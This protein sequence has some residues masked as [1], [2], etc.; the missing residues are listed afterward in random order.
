MNK[1]EVSVIV[2][3][4][5]VSNFLPKC[6]QSIIEQSFKDIEI[7]CINDG[8]TD[9]S[10]DILNSFA[11]L[12]E[13]IILINQPNQGVSKARNNGLAAAK[14]KF[15]LFIDGDDYI[16]SDFIEKLHAKAVKTG[17]DIVAS[18]TVYDEG[19]QLIKNNF[20]SKQTFKINKEI[21]S[22]IEDK[23]SFAK[24]VIA[25]GKLYSSEFVRKYNLKFLEGCRFEDNEFS[26][27]ASVFAEKIALEKDAELYYVMHSGSLTANA[28]YTDTIFDF[29]KVFKEISAKVKELT[30]ENLINPEYLDVFNAHMTNAFYNT[31]KSASET[32]KSEFQKQAV[33]ILKNID[34]N[35]KYF[36][37]KT[38]KR[39]NKLMGISEPFWKKFAI[40]K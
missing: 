9:N 28:F 1:V 23:A 19:G 7:I 2:P 12:D 38:L 17:A 16:A 22:S 30:A 10:L 27:L 6:L 11:R 13:R 40:F 34:T 36:D 4:Y 24:S 18:N 33:E 5:N 8:S 35:N 29:I 39:Y 20:I 25:S 31:F 21:L 26:F 3:I 32:Y 14:G 15:L 37:S